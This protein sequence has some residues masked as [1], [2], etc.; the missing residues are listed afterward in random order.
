MNTA[1]DRAI[2][3][4]VTN[5]ALAAFD[6]A[7][8]G[9]FGDAGWDPKE[10]PRGGDPENPGRFSSTAGGVGKEPT[11]TPSKEVRKEPEEHARSIEPERELRRPVRT[12]LAAIPEP[13]S[14][15]NIPAR[16]TRRLRSDT[17]RVKS[18]YEPGDE[19]NAAFER[20][21]ADQVTLQ[22]LHQ[23]SGKEFAALVEA[24][25]KDNPFS[26][27]VSVY[28]TAEYDEMRCFSTPDGKAGFALHG[29]DIISVYKLPGGPKNA[30]A[31]MLALAVKQGGRRLD[32]FDTVLPDLY[33]HAG[34]KAVARVKWSD[35]YAP[36]G[37][38]YERFGTW[39]SGRPDVVGMTYDPN[40][41]PDYEPGDGAYVD[42]YDEIATKQRDALRST[43][44]AGS[45]GHAALISSRRPTS[46]GSPEGDYYRRADLQ[47][48]I[49]AGQ[50]RAKDRQAFEKNMRLLRN[51]EA[52]PNFRPGELDGTPEQIARVAIDH[53]KQNLRFLYEHAPDVVRTQGH[54]WYEGA[55]AMAE[56][57]AKQYGLPL[58]SVA[59]VYAALSPQKLW[60]MNVEM[61]EQFLDIHQNKQ[62]EPWTDNPDEPDKDMYAVG[63]TIWGTKPGK[64]PTRQQLDNQRIL[65]GIRGHSL[66]Q[67]TLPAEK[68]MWIRLYA[69]TH[70]TKQFQR[71]SP[72]GRKLG[73]YETLAG[74]PEPMS[75]QGLDAL[76]SAVEAAE[77]GGDR[78][79]ISL[80][81]GSR[82][83]VRSFYNNILD[84]DSDNGDVTMD[85]HAVGA[86]LL[87]PEG[88]KS[89][90]VMHSLALTPGAD[91]HPPGWEASA[92]SS[93]SG[94]SGTYALWADAYR[95]LAAELKIKPRVLQSIT[96]EAKRRLF[97]DR[98]SDATANAVQQQWRDYHDGKQG[99]VETQRAVLRL[100][101]GME[102][103]Q[104]GG[105]STAHWEEMQQRGQSGDARFEPRGG[106]D[107]QIRHSGDARGLYRGQL[108]QPGARAM[109]GLRGGSDPRGIAGLDGHPTVLALNSHRALDDAI[110]RFIAGGN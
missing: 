36:P 59:G 51:P 84:P 75:W 14:A 79:K 108:G 103:K 30:V 24:S 5:D 97:D 80:A 91:D 71:L 105:I 15:R 17:A 109:D 53:A 19:L 12:D 82:H 67:L 7:Y 104:P 28:P 8:D 39:N 40:Y 88:S 50:R 78:N 73:T 62:H 37:W 61:A 89:Q 74:D 45:R 56:K 34:F 58:Q 23:G 11:E 25:K 101:G 87:R 92:N 55:H 99:L 1:L 43:G 60:D 77:S 42:S 21:G 83:K 29:D 68:A 22:E 32:C 18:V 44:L 20:I 72:D 49:E 76:S 16:S 64:T 9:W 98:M 2:R 47:G 3:A 48:M 57:K 107:A 100:A 38:D 96:W 41:E 90:S 86:A 106:N 70:N 4:F 52:Y 94:Y 27:A 33:S 69:E 46:V 6:A 102:G 10:H 35:E 13:Y 26:A 66:S 95:E 54:V 65:D 63:Q 110:Y 93:V 31:S 85:T 81:M